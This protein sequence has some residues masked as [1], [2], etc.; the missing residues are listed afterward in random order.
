MRVPAAAE[1]GLWALIRDGIAAGGWRRR[2]AESAVDVLRAQRPPK[3]A[4]SAPSP[5]RSLSLRDLRRILGEPDP[6]PL[7]RAVAY[8]EPRPTPPPTKRALRA[9]WVVDAEGLPPRPWRVAADATFDCIALDC[10][11]V[12]ASQC[13]ARQIAN[14]VQRTEQG[15]RGQ[16]SDFPR[17]DTRRCAQGRGIRE[18]LDPSADLD[19]VRGPSRGAR[20]FGLRRHNRPVQDARAQDAA[21]ARQERVGLLE[22]VRLLD[23]DPDPQEET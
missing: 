1:G 22:P 19:G 4:P 10:R 9:L 20:G 14:E 3:R 6:L 16:G 18:A 17:C 2:I 21:R 8:P 5:P 23:V 7:L 13:V 15:S 11:N 12:R